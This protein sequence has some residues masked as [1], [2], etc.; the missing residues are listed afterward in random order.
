MRL[1][2]GIFVIVILLFLAGCNNNKPAH[3]T[4]VSED[5][6]IENGLEEVNDTSVSENEP[7]VSLI[8]VE[9]YL[10]EEGEIV[11]FLKE[12]FMISSK[13]DLE[14]LTQL[15]L[16][17]SFFNSC[18]DDFDYLDGAD[19]TR[20]VYV[21]AWLSTEEN[22]YECLVR[23]YDHEPEN[24]YPAIRVIG[25]SLCAYS[26][27]ITLAGN[28]IDQVSIETIGWDGQDYEEE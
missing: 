12:Y 25:E 8:Y 4:A 14:V 19:E 1:K 24:D 20:F 6:V 9:N 28:Q 10:E 7:D 17:E 2:N 13:E 27:K 3:Q 26:V 18:M 15:P 23:T 22:V 5:V 11:D 16:T 21:A